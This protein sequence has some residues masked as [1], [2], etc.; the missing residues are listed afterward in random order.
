MR[1]S[2]TKEH[3]APDHLKPPSAAFWVA[4]NSQYVFEHHDLERLRVLCENLDVVDQ[5]EAAIRKDGLFIR[6]RYDQTKTHP[7][8]NTARDARQLALRALRE[9]SIDVELPEEP[10]LPRQ[11][12]RYA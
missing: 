5:C 9:L 12:R 6:D 2:K 8:F 3:P 1:V 11:S 7:A 4:L 10:R